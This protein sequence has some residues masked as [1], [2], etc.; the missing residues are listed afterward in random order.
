MK[1]NAYILSLE[2]KI[3]AQSEQIRLQAAHIKELELKVLYLLELL[4]KQGIIKNSQ[5][6]SF[7][8]SKDLF[9]EESPIKSKSEL[10]N[11]GQ[12]GHDGNTLKMSSTPDKIY[13]LKS[14]YC[15][16]CGSKLESNGYILQSKRQ[17]VILPLIQPQY[18]EYRQ[19]SCQCNKC[20]HSQKA[21][22]PSGV[23]APIQYGGDI[24][25]LVSYLSVYQ[26]IP[27]LRL[28]QLFSQVF[29]LPI[30]QGSIPNI[31][32]RV[33]K[34]CDGIYQRIKE[35]ISQST[36][37]GS[38]ETGAR[39]NSENWWIWTWQNSLNTYITATDNR[40]YQ[41]IEN[42]FPKG[43]DQAIL[44]SDR[45]PAQLKVKAKGH[46][47]CLAHLIRDATFL[48]ESEALAFSTQFKELFFDIF[49]LKKQSISEAKALQ[50]DDPRTIDIENRLNV[51][52][53]L[54]INTQQNP[55][56]ACFQRSIIK[57]RNYITPCLYHLDVPPDNNGSERAIRNIKVKQK[58]SGQFKSGQ[59]TFCTLR[60]VMDT[61]IKRGL[62]IF[63]TIKLACS[64][65][66]E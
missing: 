46:Q 48:E 49:K 59:N 21:D 33:A 20:G 40:S 62:S 47:V 28:Q 6:S 2:A 9:K 42:Q 52:L 44:V 5:N 8:P 17:V 66:P 3:A 30:S 53:A 1:K 22:F 35:E 26:H 15:G 38:D 39:V 55:N 50:I 10:K 60:S 63:D 34:R 61:L 56:S 7:P 27:Y 58:V 12:F 32:E 25:F 64:I 14:E 18:E 29:G 41:S 51:L 13:D 57:L 43:F 24:A 36:V 19:Y 4:Q 31:L 37:V 16:K 11:G 23:N 54:P 65:Q 45:L